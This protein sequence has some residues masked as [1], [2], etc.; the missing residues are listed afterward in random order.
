VGFVRGSVVLVRGHAHDPA[1]TALEGLGLSAEL[2]LHGRTVAVLGRG[3]TV[4]DGAYAIRATLPFDLVP[5]EYDL[6]VA[7][8]GDRDRSSALAE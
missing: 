3:M 8:P 7:T 6:R 2:R 4:A 5:D 1:G